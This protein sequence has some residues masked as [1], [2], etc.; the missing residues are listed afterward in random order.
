[1]SI[2][3]RIFLY[4]LGIVS[5]VAL[6]ILL[7]F[8]WM[9]SPLYAREVEQQRITSI[10][11][12]QSA[13]LTEIDTQI[14]D[15]LHAFE[16][17]NSIISMEL[18]KQNATINVHTFYNNFEITI[19]DQDLRQWYKDIVALMKNLDKLK[20]KE[21]DNEFQTI[22]KRLEHLIDTKGVQQDFP[23]D[24]FTFKEL[25][26]PID[27]S[28]LFSTA[29][30]PKFYRNGDK[31]FIMAVKAGDKTNLYTTYMGIAT[32]DDKYYLVL[33]AVLTPKLTAL[34]SVIT[35]SLPMLL[36]TLI[37][38]IL[39]ATIIF[40]KV[41]VRPIQMISRKM[42]LMKTGNYEFD[43]IS[44]KKQAQ[45]KQKLDEYDQLEV[46]LHALYR[47]LDRQ[48]NYLQE[49]NSRQKTFLAASSHQLKTP[50]TASLLLLDGMIEE[51]GKYKDT[52]KYLPVVKA[53]MLDMQLIINQ[54]L[55]LNQQTSG[56]IELQTVR[57]ATIINS[58]LDRHHIL[59]EEK[60]LKIEM[61]VEEYKSIVT[62]VLYFE[63]VLDNLIINAIHY[64]PNMERI[65]ITSSENQLQIE[66]TGTQLDEAYAEKIFEPFVRPAQARAGH[67]LG[68]YIVA[69]YAALLAM[70]IRIVNNKENN[71]VIATLLL[72]KE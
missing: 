29:D 35:Q 10:K 27:I 6:F 21:V 15:A 51:I 7:Y 64:T 30:Q 5:I 44:S 55:L 12:L 52:H 49:Q 11:K 72:N 53:K 4:S 62:D 18:P 17:P 66:N 54:L 38:V 26:E 70:E 58:L 42:S 32:T 1:M 56:D 14:N 20:Q 8:T 43:A 40:T 65:L 60:Q 63:K 69:Q 37:I 39:L 24:L 50:V 33:A 46:D 68:L 23:S 2:S 48:K 61:D 31:Q 16:T 45:L 28:K 41:L 9:L 13:Q 67:G 19:V 3:K 34:S 47:E 36:S 71:S 59:I 25:S 57:V 22:G